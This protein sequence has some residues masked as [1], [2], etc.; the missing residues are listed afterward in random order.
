MSWGRFEAMIAAS[1]FCRFFLMYQPVY[2]LDHAMFGAR[3][4]APRPWMNPKALAG[5]KS[6]DDPPGNSK[7]DLARGLLFPDPA[8]NHPY[9]TFVKKSRPFEP[10]ITHHLQV[11]AP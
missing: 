11:F 5:A 9:G 8:Q 7:Q 6:S 2:S 1:A 10:C 3:S 4:G